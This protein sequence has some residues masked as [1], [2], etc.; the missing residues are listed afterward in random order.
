MY[1]ENI[2]PP[3]ALKMG[4]LPDPI[5]KSGEIVIDIHAASVNGA[6]WKVRTGKIPLIKTFPHVLGRDFS[7]IVSGIGA[8][9]NDFQIGDEVFGVCD[10]GQEGTYCERIAMKA[11]L[12]ARKPQ[13]VSHTTACALA[14]AGLTAIVSLEESLKVQNGEKILIQGGAGGVGSF[15]IQLAKYLGAYVIATTSAKNVSYVKELGAD[16]VIDYT[17]QDFRE[18]VRD[19]DA[20]FETVGGEVATRSFDVLKTGGRA[21]FIASGKTAP[22][23]PSSDYTSLRPNVLRTRGSLERILQLWQAKIISPPFVTLFPLEQAVEAQKISES[24]RLKGKLVL[25]ICVD[26]KS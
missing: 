26:K 22:V 13:D 1:L 7:G 23:S 24:Q 6:D 21:A 3:E 2:G 4:E 12:C 5:A 11:N 25:Q 14:L 8:D 17:K 20:V 16:E 9:V 18:V 15:A 19:C 10:V